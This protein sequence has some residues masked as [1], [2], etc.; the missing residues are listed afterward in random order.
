MRFVLIALFVL[1]LVVPAF[2][3][4]ATPTPTRT[5][6]PTRT[7]TITNT[8][9]HAPGG[10]A[11]NTPT[12]TKTHTRTK[13]NTPANTFT[14]TKTGTITNTP[15]ITQTP[16]ITPTYINVSGVKVST[17]TGTATLEAIP[18]QYKGNTYLV[19]ACTWVS[20]A[21]DGEALID[22][23]DLNGDL[24]HVTFAPGADAL[25]P[26]NAYDVTLKDE[27]GVD[28]LQG[29]GADLSNTTAKGLFT[30]KWP[31]PVAGRLRLAVTNA[32]TSNG[33]TVKLY[34]ARW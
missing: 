19:I 20:D 29:G 17:T 26:T 23:V 12:I 16:T 32:G 4:T 25:Q 14:P 18:H 5:D 13:T 10:T 31:V 7:P 15:T 11:T 21:T 34:I 3:Q 30:G 27:A 24:E 28:V 9:T 8:N 1:T 22:F 2:S 33:G 6:T